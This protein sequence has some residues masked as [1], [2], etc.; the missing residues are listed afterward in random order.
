MSAPDASYPVLGAG[1]IPDDLRATAKAMLSRGFRLRIDRGQSRD[2]LLTAVGDADFLLVAAA[3]V[4][5]D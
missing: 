4:D 5:R 2:E 3:G 1:P